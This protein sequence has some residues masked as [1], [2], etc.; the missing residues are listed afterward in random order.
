MHN[1]YLYE[2]KFLCPIARLSVPS[3]LI[4]L[5]SSLDSASLFTSNVLTLCFFD[6]N[7]IKD[8]FILGFQI[9]SREIE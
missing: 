3:I 4:L 5:S 6:L 9:F 8:L 1:F 2:S 7:I